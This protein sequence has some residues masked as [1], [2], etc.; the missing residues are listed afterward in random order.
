MSSQKDFDLIIRNATVID[1]SGADAKLADVAVQGEYVR[2]IGSLDDCKG[3]QEINAGKRVLAPGFIDVHTHD[4]R[5]LLA[6]PDMLPKLSQGVTTVIGGNCGVSI[7]PLH[8][9][10]PVPPLNLLGEKSEW[11]YPDF[12]SYAEAADRNPSSINSAMLTGHS[13]LRVGCMDVLDRAASTAEIDTMKKTLAR[14]LTQGSIGLSTGLAYPPAMNAP[15]TEIVE[16]AKVV[17]DSNGIYTTHMRD[18]EDHVVDSVE[19][20]IALGADANVPV[21]VSHHKACGRQNWGRSTETLKII[22][23]ARKH[24]KIDLDV[25][26]YTA[27][28]TVL[29]S[30]FVQRA[31]RVMITWST[32]HPEMTARDLHEVADEWG[33][34]VEQTIDKLNPAGAIYFQMSDEDLERILGFDG[35]MIGSD[36][37][38]HDRHPHPR[39]WGTFPRVLGHYARDKGV[40]TLEQ[41]VHRMTGKPASVFG[42][43]DRGTIAVDSLA[44]LV[45]FD[46]DR[47]IDV[48]SFEKP[49]QISV[50]IDWV[51]V[52]GQTVYEDGKVTDKRPGR[53]LIDRA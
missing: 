14:S 46:R 19:E 52:N 34:N 35:A 48:A 27:S 25:Y 7:S 29:L 24:Q 15:A 20:T 37:L 43:K 39:L 36:G 51:M 45:L 28:S 2:A 44:D 21:V 41:A 40:M 47:V 18:E 8:D 42:I 26:P 22:A 10:T 33:L 17:H 49:D 30:N 31:E 32:P 11:I 38:P 13:T 3:R 16:L 6:N 23:E 5:A 1:G 4:D 12:D 9:R 50:G 53:L